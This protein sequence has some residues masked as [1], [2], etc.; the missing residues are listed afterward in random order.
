M[1]WHSRKG[2]TQVAKA[3][4]SSQPTTSQGSRI[5]VRVIS[6]RARRRAS[7][8]P[9]GFNLRTLGALQLVDRPPPKNLVARQ[10]E[11]TTVQIRCSLSSSAR[12]VGRKRAKIIGPNLVIIQ[13]SGD[14][15]EWPGSLESHLHKHQSRTSKPNSRTSEPLA[16]SSAVDHEA[17]EP[18]WTI[19]HWQPGSK[20]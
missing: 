7:E 5:K 17:E 2:K 15:S 3:S 9:M 6:E 14:P 8:Q 1:A 18:E 13:G 19:D 20:G 16:P 10:V 11:T 4:T 12:S